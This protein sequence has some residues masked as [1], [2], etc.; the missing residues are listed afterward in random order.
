MTRTDQPIPT[1]Q[2]FS[3]N[4]CDDCPHEKSEHLM[5]S[6]GCLK[7]ECRSFRKVIVINISLAPNEPMVDREN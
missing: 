7:C 1:E 5:T 3:I 4:Q 6:F 2:T